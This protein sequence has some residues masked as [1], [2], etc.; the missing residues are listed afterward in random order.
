MLRRFETCIRPAAIAQELPV[1]VTVEIAALPERRLG[2]LLIRE[3]ACW[4][5]AMSCCEPCWSVPHN[6]VRLVDLRLRT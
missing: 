3:Q 2:H 5:E 1:P 4:F 6:V